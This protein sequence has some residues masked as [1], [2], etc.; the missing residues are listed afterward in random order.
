MPEAHI[1]NMWLEPG[2]GLLPHGIGVSLTR[3]QVRP[4]SLCIA[5]TLGLVIPESVLGLP[6]ESQSMTVPC[7]LM[8]SHTGRQYFNRGVWEKS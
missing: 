3:L 5:T 1:M 7:C 4:L 6:K 2:M 8:A